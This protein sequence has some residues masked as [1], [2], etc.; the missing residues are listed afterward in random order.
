M[1]GLWLCKLVRVMV[2]I[3]TNICAHLLGMICIMIKVIVR[4]P[5]CVLMATLVSV[6]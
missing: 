5:K 6:I 4:I 1:N 3:H 2:A